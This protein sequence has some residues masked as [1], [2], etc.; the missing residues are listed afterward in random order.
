MK[1]KR[2]V[3]VRGDKGQRVIPPSGHVYSTAQYVQMFD[4]LNKLKPC[5][6]KVG[7]RWI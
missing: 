2:K 1:K 3:V 4:S 7:E 5:G 6:T